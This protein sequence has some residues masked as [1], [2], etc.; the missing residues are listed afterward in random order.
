MNSGDGDI[1]RDAKHRGVYPALWTDPEGY[2]C[3]SIYQISW[4]KS[5]RNFFINKRRHL[6]FV[7]RFNWQCFGDHFFYYF[8][9]NS[10]RNFFYSNKSTLTSHIL[11]LSWYLLVQLLHLP[12]KFIFWN[13][14]GTRSHFESRPK[15]VNIHGYS[16]LRKPIRTRENCYPLI[17]WILQ[18][19]TMPIENTR[20][21][22]IFKI[23]LTS[24]S[25]AHWNSVASL[26]LNL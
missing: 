7:Y 9:A 14:H 15:T 8:V 17:W 24:P 23:Q 21:K 19:N 13:C 1:Y 26:T 22:G 12:P 25:F 6:E 4:I 10:V 2:S 3:F 16:E 18:T 11:F 5:K 20:V